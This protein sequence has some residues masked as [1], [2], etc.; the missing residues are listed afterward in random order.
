MVED[1]LIEVYEEGDFSR[2][3]AK[4]HNKEKRIGLVIHKKHTG[5]KSPTHKEL[6]FEAICYG[7]I[8]TT[9]RKLDEDKYIRFFA[10]RNKNSK[11]SYNTLRYGEELIKFGKMKP[12]GI[13]AFEEGKKKL[14]HDYGL[15]ENP[16]I[17]K[18][19]ER[20]LKKNK[21]FKIFESLPKSLKK[22]YL[23]WVLRAKLE[24]TKKKRIE[25]IVNRMKSGQLKIESS[26]KIND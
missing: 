5:K 15:S 21:A 4:N 7:W 1:N 9:L 25:S 10:R 2:W 20:E 16:E 8:D 6:M 18:E 23:R 22:T 26:L 17:P 11:W 3:L 19:L 24:P 14:P 12:S 13:I